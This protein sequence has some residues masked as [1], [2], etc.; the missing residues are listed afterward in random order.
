LGFTGTIATAEKT[1][2]AVL[3]QRLTENNKKGL[4]YA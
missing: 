1:K 2:R 3:C 4:E